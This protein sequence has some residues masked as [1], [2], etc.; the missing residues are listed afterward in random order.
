[1]RP[2]HVLSLAVKELRGLLR[3]PL[4]LAL[5]F[6][7]FTLDHLLPRN[8]DARAAEPRQDRHRG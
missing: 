1:M 5:V 8:R 2:R 4:L 7:A 6:Y 3:D